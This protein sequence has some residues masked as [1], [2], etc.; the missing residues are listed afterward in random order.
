MEANSSYPAK[1]DAF[2]GRIGRNGRKADVPAI[3][4]AVRNIPYASRGN[5]TPEAVLDVGEGSCSGKHILLRDLLR[6][7]GEI[8]DVE[9]VE[10]DFAAAIP[11]VDSMP[12][13]LRRRV[14]CGGVRD[15]HNYVVWRGPAREL[16]LDATWP[17]RM[18]L[19][20]FPVNSDW[21]GE[22]DTR[23]ALEP[24]GVKARV[25]DV[26]SQKGRLLAS[27]SEDEA[28]DRRDFLELLTNWVAQNP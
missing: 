7:V 24:S 8:A 11:E 19:H 3:F 20:G 16:K 2:L 25:E 1:L 17:D 12:D 18:A 26:I 6:R 15:Y 21:R 9:I 5:R 28:A 10:G 4:H 22:G 27:L 23:L 14:R 13:E